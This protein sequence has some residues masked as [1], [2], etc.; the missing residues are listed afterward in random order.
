MRFKNGLAISFIKLGEIFEE[1]ENKVKA[2]EY[3]RQSQALLEQLVGSFPGYV[4]F[5]SNLYWVVGRLAGK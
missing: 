1:V 5:K 4:E 3:Y 2:S